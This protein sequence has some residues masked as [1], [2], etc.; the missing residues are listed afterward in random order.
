[1][2]VGS[3]DIKYPRG[4]RASLVNLFLFQVWAHAL[5]YLTGI[6]ITVLLMN[7][8]IG[9]LG[10]NFE[11]YQDQ[12]DVLFQRARAK[13]LLELQA[14]PLRCTVSWLL[15]YTCG[16]CVLGLLAGSLLTVL[17]SPVFVLL[18]PLIFIRV[19]RRSWA[20][21]KSLPCTPR[22]FLK[23]LPRYVRQSLPRAFLPIKYVIW[24]ALGYGGEGCNEKMEDCSIF[25][26]LR[27][28]PPM[29]DLRSLRSEMKS[30]VQK[31]ESLEASPRLS[32]SS[33]HDFRATSPEDVNETSLRLSNC[34]HPVLL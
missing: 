15:N 8:L 19:S 33:T 20:E 4:P 27:K 10:N 29:E 1:M 7:L 21:R 12:S 11:L 28:E 32:G 5:F 16:R 6:G 26:V 3:V 18:A 25:L 13:M 31:L 9:V 22:L 30:Q 23:E 14:R 2:Q 24:V 34:S 17:L